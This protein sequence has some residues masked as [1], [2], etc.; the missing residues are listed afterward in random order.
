MRSTWV[1]TMRRQQYLFS[2]SSSSA[3][4]A[5]R[6]QRRLDEG[7]DGDAPFGDVVCEELKVRVPLVAHHLSARETADG[8]DLQR[9]SA[10]AE[11]PESA[12]ASTIFG[13]AS[14]ESSA[15]AASQIS[16]SS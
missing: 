1:R 2:C 5:H 15:A 8:D 4:L 9:P 11:R 13:P 16:A 10:R 12:R 7:T 6:L 14:V 3:S